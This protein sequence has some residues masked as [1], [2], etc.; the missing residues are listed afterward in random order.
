MF[1]AAFICLKNQGHYRRRITH[2]KP[3]EVYEIVYYFMDFNK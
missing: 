3:Q 1:T 2:Q